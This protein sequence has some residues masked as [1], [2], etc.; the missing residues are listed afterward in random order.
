MTTDVS[1]SSAGAPPAK[2][3]ALARVGVGI[4]GAAAVVLG[5]F[6]IFHPYD[7]ASTLAWLIG[8]ALLVGGFVDVAQGWGADGRSTSALPGVL[9][10]IGGLVAL[11]WPGATLWT[12]AVIVG[13]SLLVHGILRLALAFAGRH[14]I[15]GW[16]WLALA[17][18]VNVV[19]GIMALAWPDATVAVLSLFLGVQILLFGGV[20]L[21]AAF[22]GARS[23]I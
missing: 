2:R 19:V 14:E 18:A 23:P 10:I 1:R 16:G 13:I 7:A 5:G 17:G 12:L 3:S 9:L 22:T 8:L 15:P 6:M 20:L 11:V 4:F 21:V